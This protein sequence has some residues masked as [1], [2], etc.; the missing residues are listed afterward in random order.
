MRKKGSLAWH[1]TDAAGFLGILASSQ[2]RFGDADFLNDRTERTY[3]N[4]L[5]DEVVSQKLAVASCDD[6][7]ASI[8]EE[9]KAAADA[10]LYV[11]S[12]SGT[13]ESL[14]LWQRY[15]GDGLGYC[16]GF[17]ADQLDAI[18]EAN[19]GKSV[20]IEY[21]RDEQRALLTELI[22]A[23]MATWARY[24]ADGATDGDPGLRIH[25]RMLRSE[26]DAALLSFKHPLFHDE[27]ER[28]YLVRSGAN[29]G[30]YATDLIVRGNYVK[31]FVTLPR[32]DQ[33]RSTQRLPVARVVC[34]P[35]LNWDMAHR[36]AD[37]TLNR[38][39]Y[40]DVEVQQS[41]LSAIWR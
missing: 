34:G 12:F 24:R 15:G 10:P 26:L 5:L 36:S 27:S 39:G 41:E 33:L 37:R 28:R 21:D 13:E 31:P 29:G 9:M 16:L 1:Y 38:Y 23:T 3:A 6:M 25:A 35:R 17:D 4:G 22:D 20:P 2:L 40:L 18:L 14:S 32:R 7:L 8:Y 11:C 19:D 30:A